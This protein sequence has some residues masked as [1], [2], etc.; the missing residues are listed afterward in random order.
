MKHNNIDM[1]KDLKKYEQSIKRKHSF[2]WNPKFE[3]EFHTSLSK[4]LVLAIAIKTFEKLEWDI[5]YQDEETVEAKRKDRGIKWT[6]KITVSYNYGKVKVSSVFLEGVWDFGRNSLRV[7][8]FIHAFAEIERGF[9]KAALAELEKETERKNNLDD[10]E[11][12]TEL[13]LPRKSRKPNIWIPIA[14]AT[15]TA[16]F[17][18]Y[19]LA[20]LAVEGFNIMILSAIIIGITLAF[21]LKYLV[22]ISN[23]VDFSKLKLIIIGS[24]IIIY[25]SNQCLQYQIMVERYPG[26]PIGFFEF[27]KIKMETGFYLKSVDIGWILLLVIG[28]IQLIGSYS[29]CMLLFP[30]KLLKFQLERIPPEVVNFTYYHFV[31]GKNEEQIRAELSKM[32]WTEKLDQDEVFISLGALEATIDFNR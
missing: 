9:D 20:Y 5:V 8:L 2:A 17:F 11:I 10:Y 31:K 29:F 16:L 22:R 19:V 13:P 21:I 4:T 1:T 32:G 15:L 14:G 3:E 18:G 27:M 24:I 12:P 28:A 25:A 26:Y 7:K 30:A 23:Y 6:E